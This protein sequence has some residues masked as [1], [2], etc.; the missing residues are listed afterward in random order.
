MLQ[1]L[2]VTYRIG[3]HTVLSQAS[4]TVP[5]NAK[6]ALVGRN[7]AGKSTL[8]GLIA[9]RLDADGGSIERPCATRVSTVAQ[10]APGGPESLLETVLAADHRRAEAL[11]ALEAAE[12]RGDAEAIGLGHARL[13]EIEAYSAPARAAEIL[14]GL[15]FSQ[16]E[17]ARPCMSFSG[18]WRMRVALAAALFQRPDLLLL[19]E[20]SNHLDFEAAAW[21]DSHLLRFPGTLILVSHDRQM[22]DRIAQRVLH[23]E[24]GRLTDYR[25]NYTDFERTLAQ[26]RL[27][28]E[29][30]SQA[31]AA[32]RKHMQDFVDRFRAKATKAR[33]AQS[34]LKAL[35]KLA[36]AEPMVAG[37]TVRLD[38]PDAEPLPPPLIVVERG[39][40]GYDGAAVLRRLDLRIDMDDRI[41]LLGPNGNGKS[42]LIRLLAGRL[43]PMAGAV[44]RA[45]R[46][47]VGYFAQHQA[48]ELDTE[49]SA[50]EHLR[51]AEP[52]AEEPRLRAHLGRFGLER[53]KA[54]IAA[55]ALSGGEKARLLL[56][57]MS[58]EAPHLL[59]L[60]EPTN[61]LDVEARAAL[62]ETL[63]GF[64]GAVV[65]VSHDPFLIAHVADRL[66]RLVE[67]TCQPFDGDLDDYRSLVLEQTRTG[68][69]AADAPAGRD[70]GRRVGRRQAAGIRKAQ[71]PLRRAVGEAEAEAE[72]LGRELARVERALARPETYDGPTEALRELLERRGALQKDVEAAERRW[73]EA[74]EILD[75]ARSAGR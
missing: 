66:W 40:V 26:R 50:C 29:R 34:R 56:A 58:R 18:G 11:S 19:D 65:L 21:L 48:D 17:M 30:E 46:L 54:D 73:M 3:G 20:P 70:G 22:L 9:G 69:R 55:G 49:A 37:R 27:A 1:I 74:M 63:I 59:L 68:R 10:H 64:P 71:A 15:G 14:A 28:R 32:R 62:V 13:D 36:P 53:Q 72:R 24:D 61:H 47:R 51:R 23:L 39:A 44:R 8:L 12:A 43:A 31:T 7:G 67:G 6:V 35:E 25:G 2:D 38:F 33:Q 41:A 45:A 75:A 16:D 57:L 42:T 4:A 5:L 60:D 52:D